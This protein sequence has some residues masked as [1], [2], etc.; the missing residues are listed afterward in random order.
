MT[1]VTTTTTRHDSRCHLRDVEPRPAIFRSWE[2][3]RHRRAQWLVECVAEMVSP[4]R[5][6]D[7]PFVL[8]TR[9]SVFFATVMQ[10]RLT[11]PRE[12]SD[13]D[14]YLSGVGATAAFIVGGILE[15]NGAGCTS[16]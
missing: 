3:A 5:S 9:S 13:I 15:V 4:P 10:V 1:K 2:R 16:N 6:V 11:S 12:N 8:T 14:N 7:S